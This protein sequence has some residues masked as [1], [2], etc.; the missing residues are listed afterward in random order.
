VPFR[1]APCACCCVPPAIWARFASV[2]ARLIT[3]HLR[4]NDARTG[5][6]PPAS[7]AAAAQPTRTPRQRGQHNDNGDAPADPVRALHR[8]ARRSTLQR[9]AQRQHPPGKRPRGSEEL[10]RI[11]VGACRFASPLLA[12]GPPTTRRAEQGAAAM[13]RDTRCAMG[14]VV[15]GWCLQLRRRRTR[16]SSSRR[17]VARAKA[18]EQRGVRACVLR[19]SGRW[20]T[21]V[22]FLLAVSLDDRPL[23]PRTLGVR[24]RCAR[25][26]EGA[27]ERHA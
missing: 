2:N 5:R 4:R 12:S 17:H 27:A 10:A 8:W 3:G 15:S 13:E 1:T 23:W 14:A 21:C 6:P 7:R 16:A 18:W 19:P 11:A 9:G 22:R 25:W 20:T 26:R 24:M